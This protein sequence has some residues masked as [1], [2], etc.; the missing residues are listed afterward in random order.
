M[1]EITIL[2]GYVDEP[3][4][5]GVPPFISTYPR[6]IAGAINDTLPKATIRYVTIDQIRQQKE[7]VKKLTDSSLIIVIAGMSVPGKYLSGYPAHPN[8]LKKILSTQNKPIKLLCGTAAIYGFGTSGGKKTTDDQELRNLFDGFITGDPEIVI[9]KI[10]KQNL[11]L[12]HIDFAETREKAQDI[13]VFT[14]KGAKIVCQHPYFPQRLMVEIETYR[15]CPRYLSGGCS[16]CLEPKKGAPDFRSIKSIS[17]EIKTLYDF[18]IR[19]IR[20]GNQPCL[21]SYQSKE[22]GKKEFPQPNPLALQD[23]FSTIRNVAPNLETFH[24]DNVNPGIVARYPKESVEIINTIIK[25]H[26]PGDVAAFGV[27][28]IDPVVIHQNN[29]KANENELLFAIRLFNKHGK[30]RGKNG[31]PHLLPG[32]NFIMGLKGE[33]KKT[34]EY[35]L[36]FLQ[37]ILKEQLLVRRINLRQVIPLPNTAIEEIGEKLVKRHQRQYKHFK[38]QVKHTIEQPLLKQLVPKQT[39][40]TDVIFE[41]WKGK[42]TFGRQLG[43]YPLLVGIPGNFPIGSKADVRV[44]SHG[45]RSVTALPS[46]LYINTAQR[47]TIESIPGIGKKRAIRILS[48]RPFQNSQQFIKTFDDANIAKEII[49]YISFKEDIA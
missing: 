45:F 11:D 48:N 1:L 34:F 17:D 46:P 47:E 21:F 9:S 29:L 40:L 22:I 44:I 6:Y 10:L 14:I 7:L 20:L 28:S 32:L 27:E 31:L 43:S 12:N 25:Y 30:K 15:G 13:Q 38:Y 37:S 8:E 18:G 39:I 49:P 4:C 2:D 33:T 26:T 35:N 24:I 36:H 3:T 19:H 16:F 5:L 41:L 23:L 42:T